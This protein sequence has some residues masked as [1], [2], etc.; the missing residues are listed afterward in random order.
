VDPR[1]VELS[2]RVAVLADAW[3]A[4]GRED[5]RQRLEDAVAVRRAYPPPLLSA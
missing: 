3:L 2:E 5:V 4:G 1:L